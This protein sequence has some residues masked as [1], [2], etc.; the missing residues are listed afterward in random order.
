MNWRQQWRCSLSP[1]VTVGHGVERFA[2]DIAGED[3]LCLLCD[4]LVECDVQKPALRPLLSVLDQGRSFPSAC[5]SQRK[6]YDPRTRKIMHQD[7]HSG[8]PQAYPSSDL[9]LASI[10]IKSGAVNGAGALPHRRLEWLG[11]WLWPRRKGK[12]TD[13]TDLLSL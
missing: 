13:L 8:V 6:E 7:P 3:K 10:L 5:G 2:D 1:Y 4:A 12:A 9:R 11:S